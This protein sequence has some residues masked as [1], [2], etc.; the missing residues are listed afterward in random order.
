[1]V[2]TLVLWTGW[3]G[4]GS[5]NYGGHYYQ[6]TPPTTWCPQHPAHSLFCPV[7]VYPPGSPSN[8]W[9]RLGLVDSCIPTPK[10]RPS[11]GIPTIRHLGFPVGKL[12][13]ASSQ[14]SNS[15]SSSC[16]SG[17]SNVRAQANPLLSL[18]G[19]SLPER[20]LRKLVIFPEAM[21]NPNL[22]HR[23]LAVLFE[24]EEKGTFVFFC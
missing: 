20:K 16:L 4:A 2:S 1:M 19:L 24:W 10:V 8:F 15:P 7:D 23:G 21:M 18:Y 9:C 13:E 5:F 14:S 6:S 12:V 17:S 3:E 22:D 11:T